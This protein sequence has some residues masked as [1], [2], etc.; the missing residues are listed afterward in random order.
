MGLRVLSDNMVPVEDPVFLFWVRG[1]GVGFFDAPKKQIP[2]P[3]VGWVAV[4]SKKRALKILSFRD[5]AI[6]FVVC[7]DNIDAFSGV[8]RPGI[9]RP[10]G[11]VDL[12]RKSAACVPAGYVSC[13][14]HFK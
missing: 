3:F 5:K 10:P 7:E 12:K 14:A 11:R 1:I 8:E 4:S 13:L 6:S 9:R 2:L